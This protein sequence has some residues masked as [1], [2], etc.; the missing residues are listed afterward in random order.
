MPLDPAPVSQPSAYLSN[1][2]DRL[3]RG[4]GQ[5]AARRFWLALFGLLLFT[6]GYNGMGPANDTRYQQIAQ[7][8]FVQ[9]PPLNYQHASVPLLVLAYATRL[10]TPAGFFALC[11]LLI[12]L[13]YMAI[14]ALARRAWGTEMA[15]L[16]VVLALAHPIT[17]SL[18]FW[19]GM[20]DALTFLLT[21]LLLFV[22][23]GPV[24]FVVAF[25][26]AA[27]HPALFFAAPVLL[28][29]RVLARDEGIGYRQLAICVAGVVLGVIAVRVFFAV[30]DIEIFGRVS[31]LLS[32]DLGHF[33]RINLR[34]IVYALFSFHGLL[35][36]ALA[37]VSWVTFRCNK[38]YVVVLGL[39]HL[40]FYGITFFTDDTTRV[41]AL[42]MWAPALHAL[43]YGIRCQR[44]QG[45][46]GAA[47]GLQQAVLILA[48]M[49]LLMPRFVIWKSRFL[50][51]PTNEF[52]YHIAKFFAV[53]L[54]V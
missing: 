39:A 22:R 44:V 19:V 48:L 21:A 53:L 31:W 12:M 38:A 28:L 8:P 17:S 4:F 43:I 5:I 45:E 30:L 35:W 24:V 13:G 16:A 1:L 29:L 42:L 2:A 41:F 33:L 47:I 36:F 26:G 6:I 50:P 40:V 37:F 54:G 23:A 32:K 11:L 9:W 10:N 34:R 25:V 51:M 52:Y 7:D 15:L 27:N 46:E 18:F 14:G 49:A 20:P 3:L